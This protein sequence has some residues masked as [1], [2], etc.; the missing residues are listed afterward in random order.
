MVA[1]SR[2]HGPGTIRVASGQGFG[3]RRAGLSTSITCPTQN[4]LQRRSLRKRLKRWQPL[5]EKEIRSSPGYTRQILDTGQTKIHT[6][7]LSVENGFP[8]GSFLANGAVLHSLHWH[9]I[10]PI[11]QLQP[12]VDNKC[13]GFK[14]ADYRQRKKIQQPKKKTTKNPTNPHLF[15][16]KTVICATKVSV[17]S[18]SSLWDELL[19]FRAGVSKT[20]LRKKQG[21]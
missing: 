12:P 8:R 5:R 17:I 14:I 7:H 1:G 3:D 20:S 15:L 16:S 19:F 10:F 6:L 4:E 18:P 9:L 2:L 11:Q 21:I 13:S